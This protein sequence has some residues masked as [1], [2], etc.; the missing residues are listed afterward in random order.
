MIDLKSRCD[1]ASLLLAVVCMLTCPSALAADVTPAE[2]DFNRDV[3]PILAENCYACHGFDEAAREADLRL[4]T[5]AGAIGDDGGISAIVPGQPDESELVTRVLSR[6]ADDIM[7]PQ[8]S[9]KQLTSA[10][11][12]TLQ[13]WVEQGAIYD[14]HWAFVP[15]QRTPP[16]EVNLANGNAATHPIDRFIQSRLAREGL[17]PSPRADNATLIRRLSLDLIGLPPTP[18]EIDAFQRAASVDAAEAYRDLVERLLAS[19]HYGERWGLWWLDQA[20]YADSNGYSI[21]GPRSIWKYRDWVVEAMNNDMRFDTFTIEQLAGDLLPEATESQKVA[22]GFHRNTQINQEGGIDKEQFRIDSVF[23]RVA[24]TGTVWLGLTI[25]CA[26]CHDHKFDPITQVEYYRMFAF[27]N[28]QDEPSMKVYA[29][30]AANLTA[31]WDAAKKDLSDYLDDHAEEID[32][33]TSSVSETSKKDLAS[34]VQKAL[35]TKPGKRSIDHKRIL[36]AAAQAARGSETSDKRFEQLTAQYISADEAM[37]RVPTTLVMQER[38]TPRTTHVFVKGDFT[39]PAAE[40]TPGTPAILHPLES[41]SERPN[42]LDLAN[43]IT[44]PQN[45]LTA[46]VIINRV[47]QHYFGRALCEIEND[48]GLQGSLPS[49][50]ELLDWLAVEFVEQ[51]WS[52]KEMH[53]RIVSSHAYQQTSRLNPDLQAKDP[54]NYLLGRQRRLRLDAEIIR[55]VSLTASGLLSPQLGGP[56]VHP[57]I[58]D[59]VMNQGQV[60][61]SWNTSSGEDRYRRGIYTF[62]FRATPPPSLNV[63]DAPEGLSSCTRRLRSNTPLQALTLLNDPAHVEFAEAL[64][65]IIVRDGLETAFRRC[66]SRMPTAD[67]MAILGQLDS[68]TAARAMLNLDETI[69]RE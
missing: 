68:F 42:R 51:G 34:D 28:D 15:P 61:R 53:R 50:P 40:V 59:G 32:H 43:W 16:P 31:Q 17:S 47:W 8:D 14:T 26:Q 12:E 23:D 21:D 1:S 3:R 64:E 60:R 13:R 57:P 56:P 9:G 58:P 24:T 39:R 55:D 6:D 11:K 2:V 41:A 66:T 45:P 18:L 35:D 52:L 54:E 27:L 30:D 29:N 19:P 20:R 44:S 10:Q 48:F 63:F 37:K 67:E 69:T 33:W 36:L 25:G 49:H 46:R 7:P 62:R 38:R 65:N 22:T 4:D 5:F